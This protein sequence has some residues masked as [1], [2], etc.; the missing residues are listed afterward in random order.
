MAN[1]NGSNWNGFDMEKFLVNAQ[2]RQDAETIWE[3]GEFDTERV[4]KIVDVKDVASK[5]PDRLTG[6]ITCVSQDGLRR[7]VFGPH[8]LL[9]EIKRYEESI[10]DGETAEC[11]FQC[12]GTQKNANGT[13]KHV[14]RFDAIMSPE[15]EESDE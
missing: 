7:R 9:T 2:Q 11:Y 12:M 1:N 8:G 13:R 5:F 10:G 3:W 4:Y 6:I 15:E 14:Y